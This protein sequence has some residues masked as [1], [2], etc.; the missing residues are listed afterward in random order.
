[1]RFPWVIT[2]A[3]GD[4][5]TLSPLRLEPELQIA[6]TK[7]SLWLRG[8][9]G[10]DALDA[11]LAALPARERFELIGAE[12]LRLVDQRVPAHKLPMASWQSLSAWLQVALPAAALPGNLPPG[13]RLRLMRS[14]AEREPEVLLTTLEALRGFCG[15]APQIRLDPLQ[16][17]V[18]ASGHALVRG[19]PLPPLPG[20][21]FILHGGVAVAAGYQWSPA[22]SDDV[23]ARTLGVTAGALV[24]WNEDETVGRLHAE[25]F[26][27]L[28]RSAIQA[29]LTARAGLE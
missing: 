1:M 26:V 9:A 18:D 24:L 16:F 2:L 8:P 15:N 13:I 3:P 21:R 17:A 6:E 29:T 27:P 5:M 20:K 25:Q 22:V 12:Q 11:K 23:V 10:Q 28:T 4:G 7:A 19:H 14:S